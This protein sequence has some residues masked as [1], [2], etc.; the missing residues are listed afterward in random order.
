M[1]QDG[2]QLVVGVVSGE[3][4]GEAH[5]LHGADEEVIPCAARF[6]L[7]TAPTLPRKRRNVHVLNREGY[8]EL[9]AYTA[10]K[11][12]VAV[13][14]RAPNAVMQVGGMNQRAHVPVRGARP[15]RANGQLKEKPRVCTAREGNHVPAGCGQSKR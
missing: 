4:S 12:L 15:S 2:F 13:G 5:L 3:Q 10:A 14:G 6:G 7:L 9:G 8:A 1:V 11:G